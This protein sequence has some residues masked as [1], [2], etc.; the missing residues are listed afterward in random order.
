MNELK[1]RTFINTVNTQNKTNLL[2]V[3]S[4]SL[5]KCDSSDSKQIQ[6]RP[7]NRIFIKSHSF[8]LINIKNYITEKEFKHFLLKKDRNFCYKINFLNSLLQKQEGFDSKDLVFSFI[9]IY[10]KD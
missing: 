4:A 2:E 5:S 6:V 9:L 10:L 7:P 1:T 8:C 3:Q